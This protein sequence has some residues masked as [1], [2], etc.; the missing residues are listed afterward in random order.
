MENTKFKVTPD[1][2]NG[3]SIT[4]FN[5]IIEKDR[6]KFKLLLKLEEQIYIKKNANCTIKIAELKINFKLRFLE[7]NTKNIFSED[8][9]IHFGI[10]GKNELE[11]NWQYLTEDKKTD[12]YVTPFNYSIIE[13]D[14]KNVKKNTNIKDLNFFYLDSNGNVT[15]KNP[16][17]F[18]QFMNSDSPFCFVYKNSW[19]PLI[20]NRNILD[21]YNEI[22]M[23]KWDEIKLM[24]SKNKE[25]FYEQIKKIGNSFNS[26]KKID[27]DSY[28]ESI[29]KDYEEIIRSNIVLLVND[30]KEKIKLNYESNK[31]K[32]LTFE[33]L[34]HIVI[35]SDKN[36]VIYSLQNSFPKPIQVELLEKDYIKCLK[37]RSKEERD[38][39]L[40][41]YLGKLNKLFH[42]KEK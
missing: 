29:F 5:G 16:K 28:Q 13:I 31:D 12:F 23:W 19:Y 2:F 11:Q 34:C 26:I 33:K 8:Y 22:E 42:K 24:V 27:S 6:L 38:L 32:T 40:Y 9:F 20:P 41:N 37:S 21:N 39:A 3:E 30:F 7:P 25:Q 10:K 1:H 17:K 4:S 15:D 35:V 36:D 14:V 18:Y